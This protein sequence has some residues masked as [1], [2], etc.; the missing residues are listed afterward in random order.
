[1]LRPADVAALL[2]E[3]VVRPELAVEELTVMPPAG[4]L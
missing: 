4:S 3:I 2:V 1:M